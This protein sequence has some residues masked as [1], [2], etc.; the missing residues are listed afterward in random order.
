[1]IDSLVPALWLFWH[2][3]H[4]MSLLLSL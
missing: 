1:M 2:N 4:K 3:Y